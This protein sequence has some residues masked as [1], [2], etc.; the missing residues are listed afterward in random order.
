M[1]VMVVCCALA[2]VASPIVGTGPASAGVPLDCAQ[3]PAANASAVATSF[4]TVTVSPTRV[5]SGASTSLTFT[6]V[7]GADVSAGSGLVVQL[8]P[9]W[10]IASVTAKA[11]DGTSVVATV[12][13][14]IVS[15]DLPSTESL[16]LVYVGKAPTVDTRTDFQFLTCVSATSRLA[17][18]R[19]ANVRPVAL[20]QSPVVSVVRHPVTHGRSTAAGGTAS[21][22][23]VV[24]LLLVLAGCIGATIAAIHR[25]GWRHTP[26]SGVVAVPHQDP[27]PLVTVR[28]KR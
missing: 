7:P 27:A 20:A 23:V 24:L 26:T 28:E 4:G 15:V 14:D 11:A 8:P 10:A 13:G 22:I 6:Y 17:V 12:Q 25:R 19:L 1:R 18:A 2:I 5:V 9:S 21:P 16:S 3:A